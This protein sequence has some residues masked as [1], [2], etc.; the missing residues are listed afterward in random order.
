MRSSSRTRSP[1]AFCRS[2][3]STRARSFLRK[4]RRL[5][6]S[7]AI[8][9]INMVDAWLDRNTAIRRVAVFD[10][11]GRVAAKHR[12][13]SLSWKC[14]EAALRADPLYSAGAITAT[15]E[16]A[17]RVTCS[18]IYSPDCTSSPN[19]SDPREYMPAVARGSGRT[20]VTLP[21]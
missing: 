17:Q 21:T 4:L 2:G 5:V 15:T 20:A 10:S 9:K 7:G 16:R 19:L 8:G 18:Y 13:G 3:V 1:T 14:A 11:A 12:L 6:K